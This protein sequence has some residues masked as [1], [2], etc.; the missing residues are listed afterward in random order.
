MGFWGCSWEGVKGSERKRETDGESVRWIQR[1][2]ETD[3]V[4]QTENKTERFRENKKQTPRVPRGS[5]MRIPKETGRHR[6]QGREGRKPG[7]KRDSEPS[8]TDTPIET[9]AKGPGTQEE[10]GKWPR[11]PAGL[12][13]P[14]RCVPGQLHVW[15]VHACAGMCLRTHLSVSDS[16]C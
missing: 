14:G 11:G 5:E 8:Q 2:M 4:R 13:A 15:Q 7:K 6:V 10:K 1:Q 12:A 9:E 3:R 16:R